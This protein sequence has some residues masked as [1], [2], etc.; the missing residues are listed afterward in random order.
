[1][2]A[3]FSFFGVTTAQS[4]IQRI[5]PRWVE[6]LGLDARLVGLDFPIGAPAGDYR[7][8]VDAL[9]LTATPIPRSLALAL[10]G[11]ME[12]SYLRHR[13]STAAGRTT[14]VVSKQERGRAYD[15]AREA[16]ARG[17]QVYVVCPLVGQSSQERDERAGKGASDHAPVVVELD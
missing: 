4:A 15:A 6:L 11:N 5:Y 8:A 16:L 10:F 2:T 3:V 1:M 12:L 17:E 13:P 9:S 14:A 7:A